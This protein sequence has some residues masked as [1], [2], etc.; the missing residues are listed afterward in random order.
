MAILLDR[1]NRVIIQGITGKMG[2]FSARDMSHYGTRVVAGVVPGRTGAE[3]EGIPVF[4]DVRAA[5]AET[6]ADASLVYVPAPAALDA[7]LEAFDAGCRLV[8][9]P[10]DGLPARDAMEMRAAAHANGGVL[11]GPN[12]PGIIS[13]GRAK[14]GFMPSFC[15]TPGPV[16]VIS[17]SGSLSY[18]VSKRLTLAG[19]GQSTVIGI[20]GDPVKGVT[21][22]EA[23]DF[24]H[25][26][27]E[28]S[29]IVYL[30]EIGGGDEY[31]VAAYAA[32]VSAKPVAALVVGRSAPPGKKMGH[33]G[34][35]IGS[36]ADTH[37]AKLEALRAA[38][39][40]A[41]G[42]LGQLVAACRR[43]AERVTPVEPA[44]G[45]H[46]STSRRRP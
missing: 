31:D 1:G 6:A 13:P 34:A 16:G 39:V 33:A 23:L 30:G 32:R 27:P 40:E 4:P 14:V 41:V 3:A 45:G 25:A 44:P 24:F 37:E 19:L 8:V 5:R 36:Q 29:A 21:A 2:R 43:A 12:T 28:T 10:G 42:D 18:E 35:L 22:A 9:Y 46:A 38:G 26:D 20:G 7:V 15:F 11:V 17:R